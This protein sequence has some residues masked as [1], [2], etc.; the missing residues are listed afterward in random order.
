MEA[1]AQHRLDLGRLEAAGR[2]HEEQYA[3]RRCGEEPA[4]RRLPRSLQEHDPL[5]LEGVRRPAARGWW[6]GECRAPPRGRTARRRRWPPSPSAP[7]AVP[8]RG[9]GRGVGADG[10]HGAMPPRPSSV[11]FWTTSSMRSP[12]RGDRARVIRS[13]DSG[14]G[15]GGARDAG[16][17]LVAGHA[18]ERGLVLRAAPS[19]SRTGVARAQAQDLAG[20]VRAVLGQRDARPGRRLGNVEAGDAH[21][22]P[23]ELEGGPLAVA[24]ARGRPERGVGGGDSRSPSAR[25]KPERTRAPRGASSA[26]IS[27][28]PLEQ[29]RGHQVGQDEVEAAG[30]K[31]APAVGEDQAEAHPVEA[32]VLP[33][34]TRGLG[35]V[36]DAHDRCGAPR[37]PPRPGG[38]CPSPGR[39]TRPRGPCG[40]PRLERGRGRGACVSWVPV[41][42]ARPGSTTSRPGSLRSRIRRQLPGGKDLERAGAEAAESLAEARHPVD[43][44]NVDRLARGAPGQAGQRSVRH[45][46][47]ACP[48]GKYARRAT[49]PSGFGLG[50]RCPRCPLPTAPPSPR[51]RPRRARGHERLSRRPVSRS[52]PLCLS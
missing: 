17:D 46:R 30:A 52:V 39:A 31:R 7:G 10:D 38:R 2:A 13:G 14:R 45:P 40:R 51:P 37:P 42:K 18:V 1:G 26:A 50:P 9:P 47:G 43:L 11:A 5:A 3:G 25:R 12:F 16:V 29:E 22:R 28:R 4:E 20:V 32:R 23:P 24:R 48:S 27:S 19:K 49:L 44:G 6:W 34:R 15:D 41:P 21:G 8:E 36:V 35:V 33:R